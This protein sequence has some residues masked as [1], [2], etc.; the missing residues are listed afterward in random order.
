MNPF[1]NITSLAIPLNRSNIDTDAIIPKQ[2][3]KSIKR[4]GFGTNLFDEWRYLDKGY[5]GI[6]NSKRKI[7]P[8][9]VLNNPTYKNA[10]ILLARE[11]FGCGSSREH[12]PWALEDYGIRVI[13]APSFADIFYNNCFKNAILPIVQNNE[14]VDELFANQNTLSV[15]LEKQTIVMSNKTFNFDISPQRKHR[16][17]NGLDDIGLTLQHQEEIKSFEQT[18]YNKYSWL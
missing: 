11:N 7:N 9:F 10:Q 13:I 16:L 8:N 14:I 6:D 15:D 2:F 4:T 3:L 17:I 1:K 12:A 18:Y 5:V